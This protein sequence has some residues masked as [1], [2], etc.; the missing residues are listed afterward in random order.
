MGDYI[1]RVLAKA[2]FTGNFQDAYPPQQIWAWIDDI[3]ADPDV[4]KVVR[5]KDCMHSC[6]WHNKRTGESGRVCEL[7]SEPDLCEVDADHFCSYGERKDG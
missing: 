2:Q 7:A 5:C 6:E 4:V 3:P 1:K